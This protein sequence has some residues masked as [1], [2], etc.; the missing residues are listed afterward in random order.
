MP[1]GRRRSYL[2]LAGIL[3]LAAGLRLWRVDQ[4]LVDAF[5]WRQASTAMMA[6]N[7]Y[8]TNPN[9]LYPEVSWTGPGPNYQGREFQTLSYLAS[10]GYRVFGQHESIGRALAA[11]FGTW[12]VFA[13]F[14]LVRRVWDEPR[15]LAAALMLAIIPGAI[16]IDRSFLPDPAMLSLTTTAAWL[17]VVTLQTGGTWRKLLGAAVVSA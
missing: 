8:R 17:F 9:I 16:F 15:A 3:M 7:F 6:D 12:G 14:M 4:P 5:S 11:I 13:L 10:L 1:T 2:L